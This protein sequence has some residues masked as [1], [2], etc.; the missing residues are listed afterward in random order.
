MT[1]QAR[2]S[3]IQLI[4]SILKTVFAKYDFCAAER[5]GFDDVG[6]SLVVGAVHIQDHVGTRYHEVFVAAFERSPAEV[7]C[8]E[9]PLLQ[10]GAHGSIEHEDTRRESIFEGLAAC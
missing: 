2:G 3:E 4:R 7:R 6:A 9:M 5:I 10:H 1:A 8:G